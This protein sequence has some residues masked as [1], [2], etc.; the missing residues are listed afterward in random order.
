MDRYRTAIDADG[1]I[2]EITLW[3]NAARN[4]RTQAD[5]ALRGIAPARRMTAAEIRALVAHS[6]RSARSSPVPV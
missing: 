1:D 4:E 3:I 2:T 6:L 5:A